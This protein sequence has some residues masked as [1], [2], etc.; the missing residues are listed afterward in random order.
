M[1]KKTRKFRSGLEEQFASLAPLGAF[2]Y[3]PCKLPYRVPRIYC[4]DFVHKK[5]GV[6]IECKG[7]FRPGDTAKYKAIRD[8]V[9]EELIFVLSNPRKKVRKGA[10]M[11]MGEWCE[12]EGFSYFT[13][14]QMED[15]LDYVEDY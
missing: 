9:D 1:Q 3:E 12:K 11:T 6:L 5:T 15:L 4:P 14:D 8:C 10:K 7:F 13:P 2:A